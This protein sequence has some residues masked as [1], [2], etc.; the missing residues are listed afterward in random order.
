MKRLSSEQCVASP[1]NAA[2]D[3][4]HHCVYNGSRDL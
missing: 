2:V 4:F 3:Q 1:T